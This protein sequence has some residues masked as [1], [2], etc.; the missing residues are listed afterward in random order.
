MLRPGRQGSGFWA[1]LVLSTRAGEG[2]WGE[3]VDLD[4]RRS[5]AASPKT[6][7]ALTSRCPVSNGK[8]RCEANLAQ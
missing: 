1:V 3:E 5:K 2:S 7:C 4:V 6:M 8:T